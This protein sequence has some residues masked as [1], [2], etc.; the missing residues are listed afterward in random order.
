MDTPTRLDSL[1]C[2][3]RQGLDSPA[4]ADSAAAADGRER[5]GRAVLEKCVAE[6]ERQASCVRTKR[7]PTIRA[8]LY[9][10][11]VSLVQPFLGVRRAASGR[12]YCRQTNRGFPMTMLAVAQRD[13]RNTARR[14]RKEASDIL[15]DNNVL[16]FGRWFR[17]VRASFL[18]DIRATYHGTIILSSSSKGR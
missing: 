9:A 4:E 6:M 7:K 16:L 18:P 17:K 14:R 1:S 12:H 5:S 8:T 10:D 2:S 3:P 13:E 15:V 11:N